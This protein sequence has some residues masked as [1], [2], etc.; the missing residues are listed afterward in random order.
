MG[1]PIGVWEVPVSTFPLVYDFRKIAVTPTNQLW[2]TNYISRSGMGV[3]HG[4]SVSWDWGSLFYVVL[5]SDKLVFW[6]SPWINSTFPLL[7]NVQIAITE[8]TIYG[9]NYWSFPNISQHQAIS[10]LFPSKDLLEIFPSVTV[11]LLDAPLHE[12]LPA[13]RQGWRPSR[14]WAPGFRRRW[15][16]WNDEPRSWGKRNPMLGCLVKSW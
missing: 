5:T 6:A 13:R 16:G 11:R 8:K 15:S 1:F 7:H 12:F 3:D 9:T 2:G 4:D 14:P 10:K